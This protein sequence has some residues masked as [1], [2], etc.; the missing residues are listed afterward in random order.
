MNCGIHIVYLLAYILHILFTFTTSGFLRGNHSLQCR[1]FIG[2]EERGWGELT[3]QPCD[4]R[5][6]LGGGD[7]IPFLRKNCCY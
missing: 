2:E 7:G 6:M 1:H 3:L 4:R 5:V